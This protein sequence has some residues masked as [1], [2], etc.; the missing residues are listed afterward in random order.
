LQEQAASKIFT[1]G[2]HQGS[3]HSRSTS[4]GCER[5]FANERNCG[6]GGALTQ[7]KMIEDLLKEKDRKDA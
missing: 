7:A 2:N 6:G 5:S 3:T 1:D 4:L